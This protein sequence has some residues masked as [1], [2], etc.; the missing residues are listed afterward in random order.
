MKFIDNPCSWGPKDPFELRETASGGT[1]AWRHYS[2]AQYLNGSDPRVLFSVALR[3]SSDRRIQI[4]ML[5]ESLARKWQG[6]GLQFASEAE[7]DHLKK[8]GVLADA[9]TLIRNVPPLMGTISALCRSLH[10]LASNG[11]SD[12]S[13]SDPCLPFSIF[14]SCPAAMARNR[15]ERLA[16]SVS[17]E[18]L[19]LQ[20]SLVEKAAPLVVDSLDDTAI[21]SPWKRER[22]TTRGMLHGVYVFAN[23]R[24]FWQRIASQTGGCSSFADDR[25]EAING[26]IRAVEDELAESAALT[27]TGRRLATSL[28]HRPR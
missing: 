14:V 19:H 3:R 15:V 4:E 20:L 6:I 27:S 11:D 21:Y 22:R 24:C 9:V 18:A 1:R 28:F 26:Q 17:H 16:E 25:V 7:V 23:L 10:V 2:T 13:F 8:D 12:S 5:S